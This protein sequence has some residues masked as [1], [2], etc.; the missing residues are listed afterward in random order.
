MGRL[1]RAGTR[2]GSGAAGRG[3][4][5]P[6]FEEEAWRGLPTGQR[7]K[8]E[9]Y[10]SSGAGSAACLEEGTGRLSSLAAEAGLDPRG[11]ADGEGK[12]ASAPRPHQVS[13]RGCASAAG[14][15]NLGGPRRGRRR[16]GAGGGQAG[17][18]RVLRAPGGGAGG[19]WLRPARLEPW[20]AQPSDVTST[21]S[22]LEPAA[23]P[24]EGSP[25]F[26]GLAAPSPR[27]AARAPSESGGG[28]PGPRQVERGPGPGLAGAL[29]DVGVLGWQ[30][31]PGP[32][33]QRGHGLR[34]D[35]PGRPCARRI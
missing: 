24:T 33:M 32:Q 10:W 1:R 4:S 23:P 30:M 11:C 27:G 18:G 15:A 9:N 6:A 5:A 28:A 13:S 17:A 7:R 19:R 31:C 2:P 29:E 34:C 20:G 3:L 12:G 22:Q 14:W 26:E 8:R 35:G 16:R 21:W 25:T